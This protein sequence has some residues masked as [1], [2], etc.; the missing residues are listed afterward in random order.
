MRFY[1][2]LSNGKAQAIPIGFSRDKRLCQLRQNIWWNRIATIVDFNFN[3]LLLSQR[4]GTG[5]GFS[6]WNGFASVGH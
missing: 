6:R 4:Q 2:S 3:L 5:N 1:N